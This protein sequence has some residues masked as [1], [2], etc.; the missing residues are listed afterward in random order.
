MLDIQQNETAEKVLKTNKAFR[1]AWEETLLLTAWID[2]ETDKSTT[3]AVCQIREAKSPPQQ[4][5]INLNLRN[6]QAKAVISQCSIGL[7]PRVE[8]RANMNVIEVRLQLKNDAD[9]SSLHWKPCTVR[10]LRLKDQT[11]M[12]GSSKPITQQKKNEQSKKEK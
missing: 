4:M 11:E 7:Q 9:I 3:N 6:G 1:K 5:K 10:L 2:R 12:E 8:T